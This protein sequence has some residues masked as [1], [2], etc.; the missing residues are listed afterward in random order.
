MLA[1]ASLR[2]SSI[3][4]SA[5]TSQRSARFVWAFSISAAMLAFVIFLQPTL[6]FGLRLGADPRVMVTTTPRPTRL[7][8]NLVADPTT[9]ITRGSTYANWAN[10]AGAFLVAGNRRSGSSR[11]TWST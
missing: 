2:S 6:M 8:R 4:Q 11:N 1:Q 5:V 3:T 7:L 10:L 9:A